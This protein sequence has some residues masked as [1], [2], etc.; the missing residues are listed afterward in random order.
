MMRWWGEGR[1]KYFRM[2]TRGKIQLACETVLVEK[3]RERTFADC[4]YFMGVAKICVTFK[5]QLISK[6]L[7][8]IQGCACIY[9][10][11]FNFLQLLIY[12]YL[13][14]LF[15]HSAEGLSTSCS[16]VVMLVPKL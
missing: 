3:L 4:I 8:S 5:L 16:L 9:I 12:S 1:E 14:I 7:Y 11:L 6:G 10:Y 15:N 13:I 2:H